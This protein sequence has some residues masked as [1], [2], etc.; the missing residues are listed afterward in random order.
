MFDIILLCWYFLKSLSVFKLFKFH[1]KRASY[2]WTYTFNVLH[3]GAIKPEKLKGWYILHPSK[4]F[5]WLMLTLLK[6]CLCRK[7]KSL[8]SLS[9]NFSFLP[10]LKYATSTFCTY[11][12][13]CTNEEWY[14]LMLYVAGSVY[15]RH[16]FQH[17]NSIFIVR[18]SGFGTWLCMTQ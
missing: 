18:P 16:I 3:R 2:C 13:L 10:Q 14:S 7:L 6:K 15:V 8:K 1:S 17:Y 9:E 12:L 4:G 11:T 5:F